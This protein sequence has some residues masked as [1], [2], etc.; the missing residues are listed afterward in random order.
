M[1]SYSGRDSIDLRHGTERIAQ[2]KLQP[3]VKSLYR[4]GMGKSQRLGKSK[5]FNVIASA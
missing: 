3:N 5:D 2:K 4:M 1:G